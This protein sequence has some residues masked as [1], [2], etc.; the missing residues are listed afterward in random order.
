MQ[1]LD[2][3][4]TLRSAANGSADNSTIVTASRNAGSGALQGTT[5]R[6]AADG[7]VT[8]TDLA[9]N[10]AT[11]ITINFAGT[12]L[13][14]ATS[15]MIA[16]SPAAASALAFAVQPGNGTVGAILASQPVLESQD[17][18]GNFSTVGLPASLNLS[19]SL[20]AGTGPIQGTTALD[21]GTAAGNGTVSFTDLRIDAAGADKRLTAA[22]TG[23]GSV[24]SSVFA[25][26]KAGTTTTLA[27]SINPTVFGQTVT[28][29]ATVSASSGT[30]TGTVTFK[31]GTTTLGSGTLTSGQA[32]FTTAAL[33]T[34]IHPNLTAVYSGDAN[35]LT[36]TSPTLAQT[37][38]Q[39]GSATA[40]ASSANPSV[41]GQSVVLTANVS[42]V[43]P[44]A[45]MPTGTVTFMDGATPLRT[46]TLSSGQASYTDSTLTAGA[47]LFTALYNGDSNFSTSTS[48]VVPQ[49]V[50]QASTTTTVA[51]SVNPSVFGQAVTF[52][53]TVNAVAP[54]AGTRTGTVQFSIDGVAFGA[55]VTL[56]GG[57]ATSGAASMLA[58]AGHTVTAAYS[59]DTNF[60]GSDNTGAPLTQ[61]VN[62][63]TTT[64]TLISSANPSVFEQSVTFTAT[65]TAVGPG[66]GTPSG[67]VTFKDGASA[68]G[69]GTLSAGQSTL[70][71]SALSLG[72]HSITAVYDGGG[73][74]NASTSSTLSQM[75]N[76]SPVTPATGGNAIS[77][78]TTGGAYTSL[79]GP[80]YT[81]ASLG[82]VGTGTI[83][84]TAPAGFIF[85]TGGTAPTVRIIGDSKSSRNINGAA[86]GTA[87][88]MT[89]VTTT[90]LTFSVTASSA[91]GGTPNTL[92]WQNVRVRPTAGTPLASG[93]ITKTGTAS[94]S[95][96]ADGANFGFLA[97]AAGAASKLAVQTPPSATAT[98]GAAFAQQPAVQIQDQFGNARSAANRNGDNSTVV[99][100]A[101]GAGT[102][103]LQGT[104]TAT[105]VNGLASFSNLSYNKAETITIQFTSGSLTSAI[106]GNV[107]VSPAA[108]DRLVFTTQPGSATYGSALSPQPVLTSRDAFGNDSTVG[109][110]ANLPVTLG[111]SAGTGLLQG[112]T[113]LDIGTSAGNGTV[114]CSGLQ[115]SAAGTGKQLT[116]AAAGLAS[117]V[118]SSFTINPA[119]VT[120]T[121]TV[122]D[123]PYDATTAAS[124]VSR[125]LSGVIGSDD[126]TLGATGTATFAN[127]DVG[128]DKTVTV[129]GLS[130]TGT[131]AANYTLT[132]PTTKASITPATLTV[133]GLVAG[134]KVYDSTTAATLTG[135]PVLSGVLG[136][137]DVRVAGTATG[138]FADP[139][140]GTGKTVNVTG[141][142]LTGTDAAN[143]TLAQPTTTGNITKAST[144]TGVTSSANPSPTGSNVTFTATVSVLPPGGGTVGGTVQFVVD[145]APFGAPA[146]LSGGVASLDSSAL[147]H[148]SHTVAAEYTGDSNFHG[149]TNTLIPDQLV[150]TT[151]VGCSTAVSTK[152]NQSIN[153][154]ATELVRNCTDAE[155]DTMGIA[156]VTANSAQGGTVSLAGATITYTPPTDY[157]GADSFTYTLS[158]SFGATG[159]GMVNVTVEV[160]NV[161]PVIHQLARQPDGNMEIRA[162]GTPGEAYLIQACEKLGGSWATI[163]TKAAD[164]N[165]VILFLDQNATNC[166][167]RFYRLAAL[168][169]PPV[170]HQ[171]AQQPDGNMELRAFGIPDKAYLIQ[172]C[173]N[174]GASW[175]TIGTNSADADGR[176]LF[177]DQN[178][179]NYTSRFYR[180][181]TP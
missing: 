118:S 56:S 14:G 150:N 20:T 97:E 62:Q 167:I 108:A 16:V 176:I 15:S 26:N 135:T 64:T 29:T 91:I 5:S 131:D 84:L 146:T 71:T 88:A 80:V 60:T 152:K 127:K 171:L 21:I 162:S 59:G 89:S 94:M 174:L 31:D 30:P 95:G 116:A 112:T 103:T 110:A 57:I 124:I 99:T 46:N 3:F 172:A 6:T 143:Y 139:S 154:S 86:S 51:S 47:H 52:T 161:P 160:P 43:P 42:A 27:S 4:G 134:D 55:P 24:L 156:A 111:L 10:V 175:A 126:V 19:V 178:A 98:A 136:T 93:Y 165:G 36:S 129:T 50:N 104:L 28:L 123:K 115:V 32:A 72:S 38:N 90:Q 128:A 92:T 163:G 170:I 130:L 179:T 157:T 147:A 37:V 117:A 66:S 34:G 9:H 83:I 148:G 11:N 96:V 53:A 33:S 78:D 141:L 120:A 7:I 41:F 8:F 149:S 101:R 122:N 180:L 82:A 2:Q 77:A 49:S 106:S 173:E 102:T 142:S 65:V 76:N 181:T 144:T 74:F 12:G 61:T 81:E 121:V 138:A 113:S 140:A 164:S 109:L 145:G 133:T 114:T 25:V 79:T 58:V 169:G 177:L 13:T 23:L 68:L 73:S 105:A 132:Q 54:G 22:A 1:V 137:D 45:G 67:T 107:V 168:S 87:L 70:V 100:A 63:A 39:A 125:S 69:T 151:P 153:V 159:T 44:G 85:D 75:V 119:T 166:T 48:G 155:G 158:D 18:F 35:Y 40:L 17:A